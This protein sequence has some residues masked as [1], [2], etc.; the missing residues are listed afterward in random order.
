MRNMIFFLVGVIISACFFSDAIADTEWRGLPLGIKDEVLCLAGAD[1]PG[2]MIFLG[3]ARGVYSGAYPYEKWERIFTPKGEDRKITSIYI[4]EGVIY[5]S[6]GKNIFASKDSG[7]T[8]NRR[9]SFDADIAALAF[10]GDMEYVMTGEGLFM[11]RTGDNLWK[12]IYVSQAGEDVYDN[13]DAEEE[14]PGNGRP[15]KGLSVDVS[16]NIYIQDG[17]RIYVSKDNGRLWDRLMPGGIRLFVRSFDVT[18]DGKYL[19]I[20]TDSGMVRVEP[21]GYGFDLQNSG[22]IKN[23]G[24]VVR[25]LGSGVCAVAD[26]VI[27]FQDV[28]NGA[29]GS[30][31]RLDFGN[32]PSIKDVHKMVIDYAE[33]S[34]DKIRAWRR[35]AGMRAIMPKVSFRVDRSSSDTYEIYTSASTTYTT[36][37]PKDCTEGWDLSLSWDL[38]DLIFQDA[39][40]SIDTRSKLMVQLREE[41]L[42]DVTRL[43]YERRKLQVELAKGGSQEDLSGGK[44]LKLEELTASIDAMTGG[45][46]SDSIE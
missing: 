33:V 18:P 37:G 11:K 32:E 29:G 43:Y 8:W 38:G 19:Y 22:L 27:Y 1:L 16:G 14:D 41:L 40:T 28:D 15:L 42:N 44:R 25:A 9:D 17:S 35:L 20:S 13:A 7:A 12:K 4:A 45:A 6:A 26:G 46:F 34:P 2:K 31:S 24:V 21:S 39:Q 5:A 10:F 30:H 36:L 3:T 23:S